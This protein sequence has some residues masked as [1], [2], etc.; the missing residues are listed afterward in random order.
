MEQESTTTGTAEHPTVTAEL[1]RPREGRILGGVAQGLS[2]HYGLPALLIRALFVIFTFAGGLGLALYAAGWFL[3]RSEDEPEAPASRFFANAGSVRSWVGIGLVFLAVLIL[4]DKFTFLSGGVVWAVGLLVVGVLLYTGDLPRLVK[5]PD[6]PDD[7]EG[8]QR[9]TTTPTLTPPVIPGGGGTSGLPPAPVPTPPIL[10]PTPAVPREKSYL[11]RITIALM[12]IGTAVLAILDN[13]PTLEIEPEPRHYLALAVTIL[14]IGLIVGGF[15]GRARWLIL[16][17]VILIPTLLFSPVF[18]YNWNHE[19]FDRS[20]TPLTFSELE[21][22]YQIDVGSLSIDLTE[23]PWDGEQ[24]DLDVSVDAGEIDIWL[25]PDVGVVGT[26]QVH[27][28]QVAGYGRQA[29]GL[30]NPNLEFDDLGSSGTV[31]LDA[32]VDVGDIEIHTGS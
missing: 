16:V 14:G 15:L 9:M 6:D 7:K 21:G 18:E 28:G 24:I 22:S 13:I 31:Y 8:V 27:V 19:S 17:G 20:E 26:A 29:A 30:G 2:N 3:I 11:G 25:P 23:L 12:L 10:P 32:S 1:V 5:S 4:V